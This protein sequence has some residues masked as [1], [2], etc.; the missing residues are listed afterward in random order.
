MAIER[1]GVS[2]LLKADKHVKSR[3]EQLRESVSSFD[4]EFVVVDRGTE[5]RLWLAQ[6]G[7]VQLIAVNDAR[8]VRG[9]MGRVARHGDRLIYDS[10]KWKSHHIIP[11]VKEVEMETE[12]DPL[13]VP[14]HEMS[15]TPEPKRWEKKKVP[16]LPKLTDKVRILHVSSFPDNTIGITEALRFFGE[17]EI[18][19][20]NKELRDQGRDEMNTA[21]KMLAVFFRPDYIFMEECFTGD[22]RPETIREIKSIMLTGVV[23]WCGD[24]RPEI[25]KS[26]I[27]MAPYVDWTLMSN[28]PQVR[29]LR[30]MYFDAEFLPAGVP[31]WLYRPEKPDKK[32]YPH[33]I[34][35]LGSPGRDYPLGE[36]REEMTES[37]YRRYGDRFAVYGRG[38][39]K[40]RAYVFPFAEPQSEEAVLYSSCKVAVGIS[41]FDYEGYTSARMWKA[42]ASGACYLPHY[43]QGIEKWFKQQEE[44]AW[45]RR[46]SELISLIE[47]YLSRDG[48]REKVARAGLEKVRLEHSWTSRMETVLRLLGGRKIKVF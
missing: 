9:L 44:V 11:A 28:K 8:D 5:H 38:W 25:P 14:R 15:V 7:D 10:G 40:K 41:A 39:P 21:L 27:A 23:N 29:E 30:D 35:F 48:E 13:T 20:W 6:Q 43:F 42:M 12:I 16:L 32:K 24:I 45:W 3:I 33:D 1:L 4:Y 19:D 37:L 2:V 22:V 26:M 46:P 17:V 18:F 34:V 36:L 31:V 47:Y